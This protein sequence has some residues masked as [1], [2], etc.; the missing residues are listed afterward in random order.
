MNCVKPIKKNLF[1]G[2][3]SITIL[4]SARAYSTE[5]DDARNVVGEW[6]A[7]EKLLS[8]EQADWKSEEVVIGDMIALLEGEK[9]S[10]AER[11][12]SAGAAMSD[13]DL[14]RAEFV[15]ERSE[16]IEAMD[17]LGGKIEL[18][19]ERIL[20]VY[21]RFPDPL[22]EE[23]SVLYERIPEPS[24]KTR[25]S[26][27]QRLQTV[28]AILSQADK[29]NGGIQ[30]I[31]EIQE[32]GDGQA[33]VSILYFGLGGAF[34]QDEESKYSGVGYPGVDG[35]EWKQT[36]EKAEDIAALFAVYSGS[37]EAEFVGLPVTIH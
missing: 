28:V 33:E 7:V 30:L 13:A 31:S 4:L 29:F 32:V 34:F 20:T 3:I 12:E 5:L 26:A 36:P 25:L 10:L 8:E 24:K 35:W 16:Y 19:E 1:L 27:S 21:K 15:E 14:K 11:I 9:A 17:F 22:K 6:V 2:I 37:T 18:L 23:I